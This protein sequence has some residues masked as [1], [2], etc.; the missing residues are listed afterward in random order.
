MLLDQFEDHTAGAPLLALETS[1]YIIANLVK[2]SDCNT[3]ILHLV[4]YD[5]DHPVPNLKVRLD[6]SPYLGDASA[7]ELQALSP[8]ESPPVISGLA[9]AGPR[10]SFTLSP[11]THYAVVVISAR[12]CKMDQAT[13]KDE[14]K[15]GF[16][17]TCVGDDP[18]KE[19]TGYCACV[20]DR[21]L[22]ELSADQ[23]LDVSYTIKYLLGKIIP[24]C[25]SPDHH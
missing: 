23:L 15:E 13:F 22:Q 17:K 1:G 9:A 5:H 20:A 4:N 16:M 25:L 11:V 12:G 2:K 18:S 21:A 6:L 10:L 7:L 24:D 14:W 3:F 19:K 8:D